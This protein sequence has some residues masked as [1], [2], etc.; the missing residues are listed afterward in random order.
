[1]RLKVSVSVDVGGAVG[2][3]DTSS[4]QGATRPSAN[5]EISLAEALRQK[6]KRKRSVAEQNGAVDLMA[7]RYANK[8]DLW[9]GVPLPSYTEETEVE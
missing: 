3:V 1:V 2:T 7:Y 9:T 4:L 8:L 5:G 6:A